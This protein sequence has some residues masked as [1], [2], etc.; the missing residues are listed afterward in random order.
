MLNFVPG[1]DMK[2]FFTLDYIKFWI[3]DQTTDLQGLF[4]YQPYP[5]HPY[6]EHKMLDKA[7]YYENIS[8]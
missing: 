1:S 5:R 6:S 8:K 2:V 3:S 7:T 4:N